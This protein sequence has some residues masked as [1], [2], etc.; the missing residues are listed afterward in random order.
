VD[1]AVG[2]TALALMG[3]HEKL[4]AAMPTFLNAAV[5]TAG[6]RLPKD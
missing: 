2:T 6:S 5:T 4:I 3:S 1:D